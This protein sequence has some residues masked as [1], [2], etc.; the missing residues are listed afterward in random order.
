MTEGTWSGS[1]VGTFEATLSN[2]HPE[3]N[4]WPPE[5]AAHAA[6]TSPRTRNLRE[7]SWDDTRSVVSGAT[8]RDAVRYPA[9]QDGTLRVTV[10]SCEDLV[11]ADRKLGLQGGF[12]SSD[13][14]VQLTLV[15]AGAEQIH[16]TLVVP[17]PLHTYRVILDRL[18]CT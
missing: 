5:P 4:T 14:Y 17:S 18:E 6:G 2:D 3:I 12:V 16:K 1:L 15:N 8:S 7:V 13:P 9:P 10:I 11:P